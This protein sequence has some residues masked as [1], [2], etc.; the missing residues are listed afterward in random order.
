MLA[1]LNRNAKYAGTRDSLYVTINIDGNDV[2]SRI[3][4]KPLTL[5]DDEVGRAEGEIVRII[6]LSESPSFDSNSLTNSSVRVGITGDNLWRPE[7]LLLVGREAT[8]GR[9]IPLAVELDIEAMVSTIPERLS[10]NTD[11]AKH[12]MPLRLVGLGNDSTVIR[13]VLLLVR[14]SDEDDADT[15]DPIE[16]EIVAGGNIV[17]QQEITDTPQ[18][19]LQ[20]KHANW[21]FLDVSVPFTR[22]DVLSNGLIRLRIKGQDAWLPWEAYVYGFDTAEGRPNE[23]V[24]LV[25]MS[26]WSLG[27]LSTDTSEGQ[28]SVLLPISP[29]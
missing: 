26:D 5:G 9:F 23:I 20:L 6:P 7:H 13:R 11:L 1:L 22:G 15:N 4:S 16:L 29:P 10:V 28:D 2:L 8:S 14:T 3:L 18:H 17:L 27:W 12:S 25:S 19:D 21:Y 24:V